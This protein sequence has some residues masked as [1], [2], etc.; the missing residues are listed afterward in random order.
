MRL[1]ALRA[2]VPEAKYMGAMAD[3]WPEAG[4]NVRVLDRVKD[5]PDAGVVSPGSAGARLE[6]KCPGPYDLQTAPQEGREGD[7]P[8]SSVPCR[9]PAQRDGASDSGHSL[10]GAPGGVEMNCGSS[11]SAPLIGASFVKH[12]R[13]GTSQPSNRHFTKRGGNKYGT[14]PA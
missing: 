5:R 9:R 1:R 2:S 11:C 8:T 6:S 4:H 12:D 3:A 10:A 14:T 13:Y 7:S